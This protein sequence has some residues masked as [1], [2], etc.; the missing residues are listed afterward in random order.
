[1]IQ[2]QTAQKKIIQ[3]HQLHRACPTVAVRQEQM[4]A[5]GDVKEE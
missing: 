1:M 3:I 5:G 4:G 2:R